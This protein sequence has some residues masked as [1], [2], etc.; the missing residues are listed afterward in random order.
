MSNRCQVC[1][2]TESQA[3]ADARTLGLQQELQSGRYTCCQI[4]E[5]A[6]EQRLAWLEATQADGQLGDDVSRPPELGEAEPVLLPVRL[7]RP[8]VPWFRNPED[9]R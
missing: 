9:L 5:W 8:P 1:G 7:R 3:M 4:A 2:Y 6:D